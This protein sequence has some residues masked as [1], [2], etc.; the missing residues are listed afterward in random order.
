V[1][2]DGEE[3]AD[4]ATIGAPRTAW[5]C[6]AGR[7]ASRSRA[8]TRSASGS[9]AIRPAARGLPEPQADLDADPAVGER[10]DFTMPDLVKC[11][12]A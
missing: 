6:P 7:T 10:G 2:Q 11:R 3:Q 9:S 12:A 4:S 8:G 1:P 5:R